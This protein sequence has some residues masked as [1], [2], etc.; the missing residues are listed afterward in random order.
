MLLLYIPSNTR[1]DIQIAIHQFARFSHCPH[2]SHGQA[3]K[4]IIRYLLESRTRR[5]IFTPN[6][7]E[8]LNLEVR[9]STVLFYVAVLD[10]ISLV[11]SAR[12]REST[13]GNVW[14]TV[15]STRVVG[16]IVSGPAK[17]STSSYD[18]NGSDLV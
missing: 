16:L 14:A 6:L 10:T 4:R 5:L 15:T 7:D 17:P 9:F 2:K 13:E 8:H 1:P 3:L 11:S 12:W 18:I